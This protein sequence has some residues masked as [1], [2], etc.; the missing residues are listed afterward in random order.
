MACVFGVLTCLGLVVLGFAVLLGIVEPREAL[1]RIGI[2]LALL[3]LGPA[4]V[5]VFL[6]NVIAPALTTAWTAAKPMLAVVG[7]VLIVL[8]VGW[9]VLAIL[10]FARQRSHKHHNSNSFG[11]E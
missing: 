5:I 11:Q 1:K 7:I 4:I 6:Q 2:F 8:L 3:L 9:G 10:D